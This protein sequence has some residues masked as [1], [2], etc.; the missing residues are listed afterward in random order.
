[1]THQQILDFYTRPAKMTAA[2]GHAP[3]FETLPDDIA[4]L[5]RVV[6]GLLLHEHW[7]PAYDV[8]L[9]DE[10]RSESHLRPVEQML[11]RIFA[12]DDQPR[13]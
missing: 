11:D 3:L 13:S 8:T 12:H 5:V 9:S 10:R 7:A 1:M 4:A 2:A 6:Q